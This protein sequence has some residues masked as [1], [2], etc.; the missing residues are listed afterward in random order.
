MVIFYLKDNFTITGTGVVFVYFHCLKTIMKIAC[1]GIRF[2]VSTFNKSLLCLSIY[3]KSRRSTQIDREAYIYLRSP[4]DSILDAVFTVSP[5]KQYLGMA[6]PTT[7]ATTGP[8]CIPKYESRIRVSKHRTLA[9]TIRYNLSVLLHDWHN[10]TLY[11][12]L[13]V[14]LAVVNDKERYVNLNKKDNL[15]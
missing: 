7:P 1:L 2:E 14:C 13:N 10:T 6:S 12:R 5:N 4:V 8:V 9:W 3:I 11:T 15:T